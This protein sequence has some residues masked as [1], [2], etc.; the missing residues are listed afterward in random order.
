RRAPIPRPAATINVLIYLK[1]FGAGAF[2]GLDFNEQIFG[3][4]EPRTGGKAT[5]K[6]SALRDAAERKGPN[7]TSIRSANCLGLQWLGP[8]PPSGTAGHHRVRPIDV[9]D[10]VG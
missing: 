4:D 3:A 9:I 8:F 1:R 2:G 10:V 5:K 7:S 6:H